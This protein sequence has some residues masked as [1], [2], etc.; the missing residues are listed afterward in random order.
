MSAAGWIQFAALVAALAVTAPLVGRYLA[1]VYEDDRHF[2]LERIVYRAVGVDETKEQRWT[3]YCRSLLA[4]SAVSVLA[5]YVLQRVQGSLPLNPT[6]AAGTSPGLAFNTAV[7]F[8]TNT[9]WQNYGGEYANGMSHL[10]QMSG[11]AVQNF[12]SAAVGAAVVVAM[13]RGLTR[14]RAS[15]IGNFWVDL[16]RTT[17][18][19]LLPLS[20]VLAVVFLARGVVDNLHGFT[21]V[22]T[23]EGATQ[24]IPGGPIAGQ[25]AIKQL[26]T[27]GGGFLN[28]NATHPFENP[29]GITNFVSMW[30]MLILP[31]AFPFAY[32]RMVGDRKQGHVL[33]AVMG[34]F[35]V[36]TAL[37]GSFAETAGNAE[38]GSS[39][40]DQSVSAVQAGGNMEGKDVR[41]G[42]AS[43]GVWMAA[44]TGT[45]S[46]AVNC[47]H[48]SLTAAG[49]GI[50]LFDM[51]LGEVTPGGVGVGMAG[52]LVNALLA[53]FIAGLMVG[54]TPEYLGKKIQASEMKLVTLYIL[55]MPAAVLILAGVSVVLPT[56]LHTSIAN[57]GAHGLS[58]VLY[59]FASAGNNNGSAF[60]G[61]TGNTAW[62]NSAL[63][64]AMLVGR[65]L[66]I[67]PVLAIGGSLARKQPVPV[68]AGTF[69]TTSPLFGGLVAGVVVIVAGLTFFPALAL[70][71]IVE[72]LH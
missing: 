5:L 10:L 45:S 66:L 9:N 21:P 50:A 16:V 54:R 55:A 17:V 59:A 7:S 53:V 32:G 63:G 14:R 31:F 22:T 52:I 62:M 19:V 71:P 4:F 26:G 51:F 35:F 70:G 2:A 20:L 27:N 40:V 64:V 72:A 57:P 37:L 8:V 65:F 39:G 1:R 60:G 43:C 38:L 13:I 33:L 42:P 25:I 15:T 69:P 34:G 23:V 3:A 36:A 28:A 18:R 44:T 47:Q 12:G 67:I 11:L 68:T 58:E 61:L 29:D 24:Q 6:N 48:D 41:F 56:V 46:G 30:A 49:G